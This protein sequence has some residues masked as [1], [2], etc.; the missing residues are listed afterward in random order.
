MRHSGVGSAANPPLVVSKEVEGGAGNRRSGSK[1]DHGNAE[2][3]G[4]GRSRSE[5]A[6]DES[7]KE[8]EDRVAR[9]R[10]DYC[11]K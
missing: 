1:S 4:N 11:R 9:H 5:N 8:M 3:G 6:V 10:A 2:K 7:S